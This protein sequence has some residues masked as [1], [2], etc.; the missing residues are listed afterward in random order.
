MRLFPRSAYSLICKWKNFLRAVINFNLGKLSHY[1][2]L[3]ESIAINT[4]ANYM[5]FWEINPYL[6]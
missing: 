3:D 5:V 1:R 6:V 4:W 2:N